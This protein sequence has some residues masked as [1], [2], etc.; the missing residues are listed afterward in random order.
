MI[1][2]PQPSPTRLGRYS[3]L[4]R[5]GA[6]GMAEVFLARSRGAEG[7]DKLLVVKRILPEF[8]ENPHFRAMF[9]DEARVALRLNHPNIVQVYGFESDGTTQLLIMEHIDGADL[10]HLVSTL[11][12]R[13]ENVPAPLAAYVI[14]EVARGLHYAHE[15]LDEQNNPLEI[16]HRDVSPNNVLLSYEGAVKLGDFGIARVRSATAENPGAV[17]G[18]VGYMS[19]EQARGEPVDRRADVYSLGVLL[20]ELLSGRPLFRNLE[21]TEVLRRLRNG[22]VPDIHPALANAPEP[23][24]L[25]AAR[26]VCADR[27]ARFPSTRDVAH[28]LSH[29]L[30]GLDTPADAGTLEHFLTHVVPPKHV[31][32]PPISSRPPEP[33]ASDFSE[34]RGSTARAH[35]LVTLPAM[36]MPEVPVPRVPCLDTATVVRERV[37]VAVVAGR[38]THPTQSPECRRLAHML[39]ELAFKSDATLEWN[40]DHGFSLVVG[41]LRPHVDDALRAARLGLEILDAARSLASDV[42]DDPIAAPSVMLGLARGA[43]SCARDADGSMV[44]YELVDDAAPLATALA[45]ASTPG[46]A[47]VAGGF[48]RV[49][50]RSFVLREQPRS[51]VGNRAFVLERARSRTERD[52][53][54]EA[55][56]WRLLGRENTLRELRNAVVGASITRTGRAVI[57]VGELGIGKSTVLGAFAAAL[58]TTAG[59]LGE[60]R[61]LRVDGTI[62]AQSVRYDLLG[63]LLRQL[64]ALR[65]PAKGPPPLPSQ[66]EARP[67]GPPPLP[68]R[69]SSSETVVSV[70]AITQSIDQ[71]AERY[72]QGAAGRRA[73]THV[74]QVALGIEADEPGAE[75]TI[76]RE[77]GMVL[78]P[79]IADAARER[80]VVL[81]FDALEL[82]DA[83]SRAVLSELLRK[84]PQG[85]VLV[86]AAL[87]DDDPFSRELQGLQTLQIGPLNAEARRRLIAGSTGDENPPD[88]LVREVSAVAGGNPLTILEVVE[89]LVEREQRRQRA[90]SDRADGTSLRDEDT[91]LPP[92]LDEV[93]SGRLDALGTETRGLLRWCA[94]CEGE[95]TVDLVDQ[96]GGED[97]PRLRARLISD[98]VLM[99]ADARDDERAVLTFAHPTLARVTRSSIEPTVVPAMH[100]RIAEILEKR[101]TVGE[102][103]GLL[104][105]L[106]KHRE[107][108]GA[109][110]LA[111][112]AWLEAATHMA[113]T[114]ATHDAMRAYGKV[115][116]LSRNATDLEGYALRAAAYEGREDLA[117]TAGASRM[118]RIE[119]LCLRTLA[120]EA[121]DPRL[122]ARA[123]T[124]QARYKLETFAADAERDTV[125]AVRAARRAGEARTEAEA[126]WALAVH[127]ARRGQHREALTELDD[128]LAA[129]RVGESTTS[130]ATDEGARAARTLRIEV[131]LAK[132]ERLRAMGEPSESMTAC[133]EAHA[134]ALVFG[135][136]RLLGFVYDELGM[137]CMAQGGY[138]DALRFF[139]AAVALGRESGTR[140]RIAATLVHGAFALSA[141]GLNDRALAWVTR[142][143]DML[144]ALGRAAAPA[145]STEVHVA[146]AEI[147]V[148]RGDIEGATEAMDLARAGV[149]ALESR[150]ALFRVCVG[151]ARLLIARKQHRNARAAA[152]AA[153]RVARESG[154][155]IESLHARALVAEAAGAQ[156][157][158]VAA[159]AWLDSVL[160]DPHFADPVRVFRGD[161]IVSTCARA[162]RAMG[163][164]SAATLLD[165]RVGE[166]RRR[167]AA[168]APNVAPTEA[169]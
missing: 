1:E 98:G 17:Q 13:G 93:L 143:R 112:R 123:L 12:A 129:L 109:E 57:V 166:M 44:S 130:G 10:G 59:I 31:A 37:N 76:T 73:A 144:P 65:N 72:G 20:T 34:A 148:E 29:Y 101:K 81:L 102:G 32:L 115:L 43:A 156:G 150:H 22:D 21:S 79:M 14:R 118:R 163:E 137:A 33:L 3:V 139:R 63:R 54:A 113:G 134:L 39:S 136:R 16:V 47:L 86:V 82:A 105:A 2:P 6:G 53:T 127:R 126:R 140:D 100:A 104:V 66:R 80:P 25:I 7:V 15:R 157:D 8:G 78:R 161:A 107:A 128:A 50:R 133:A 141:L 106:A 95:L 94:L 23:L 24:R 147:L 155:V 158:R 70:D 121:R 119:L 120:V 97:G 142:A 122:V 51:P 87:R 132:A 19:P 168:T 42:E 62:A 124:R 84:P 26:A 41:V 153:A 110:R 48:Y 56:G 77:L 68:T 145:T 162:L 152:E 167:V 5:L 160:G 146:Q 55:L 27:E 74:M 28:A 69:R 36:L 99:H 67:A 165:E 96:I 151:D 89:A 64:L 116:S 85:L 135:P 103:P 90:E 125:A 9:V 35:H 91:S 108:A 83:P 30:H 61:V 164:S 58:T 38:L 92:S 40:G 159:R 18:K 11:G 111:A 138:A 45:A 4:Q 71:A 131:L 169:S 149:G 52:R 60:S 49:V 114:I 117:R 154:L 46:V 88:E 75:A